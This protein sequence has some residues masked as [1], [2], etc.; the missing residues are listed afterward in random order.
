MNSGKSA[1]AASV[2]AD[3]LPCHNMNSGTEALPPAAEALAPVS[4]A[5]ALPPASAAKTSEITSAPEASEIALAASE[6]ATLQNYFGK[7]LIQ[8]RMDPMCH[9]FDHPH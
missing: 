1:A 2:L 7:G 3:Y 5:E 8:T 6:R 4:A 9:F